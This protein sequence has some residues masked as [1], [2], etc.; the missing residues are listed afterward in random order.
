MSIYYW[1]K[2]GGHT[3]HIC[4][5]RCLH[6]IAVKQC[7]FDMLSRHYVTLHHLKGWTMVGIFVICSK[8]PKTYKNT[9]KVLFIYCIFFT[10]VAMEAYLERI[11]HQLTAVPPITFFFSSH[12]LHKITFV[13]VTFYTYLLLTQTIILL[14][15]KIQTSLNSMLLGFKVLVLSRCLVQSECF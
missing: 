5:K 11:S 9:G 14:K 10:I 12:F 1:N 7:M 6:C 13:I 2:S 4:F 8:W 3:C 15:T